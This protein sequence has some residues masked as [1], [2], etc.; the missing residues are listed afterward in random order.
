M[1][2]LQAARTV[3]AGL[4]VGTGVLADALAGQRDTLAAACLDIEHSPFGPG[5]CQES[6]LTCLRCPNALVTERHLPGLFTVLDTIQT[7]LETMTVP[8]WTAAHGLTWLTITEQLMPRFTPAQQ[9]AARA[10]ARTG[11]AGVL[12]P[13]L[14]GLLDGPKEPR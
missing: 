9:A 14:L 5:R 8:D 11:G 13:G 3:A 2:D 10:T 1:S 6:F 7:A 12:A 4:G